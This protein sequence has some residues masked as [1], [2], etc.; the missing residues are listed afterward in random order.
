MSDNFYLMP[1]TG[2]GTRQDP[3]RPSYADTL[4]AAGLYWESSRFGDENTYLVYVRDIDATTSATLSGDA[5]VTVIPPLANTIQSVSV[6]DTVRGKLEALNVPAGWVVVG[7]SYQTVLHYTF[8]FFQILQRW[9]GLG[10]GTV[11]TG[12]VTLDTQFGSLG[13]TAQ[14]RIRDVAASFG[15]DSSGITSTT[16]LRTI[17][18]TLADQY[19]Q[20]LVIAGITI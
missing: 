17:L 6:R 18:K 19:T 4:A 12:G 7:M 11:F 1:G 13:A 2:T 9:V 3:F 16:T 5:A 14:Q 15:M 10:G 20:P 8:A